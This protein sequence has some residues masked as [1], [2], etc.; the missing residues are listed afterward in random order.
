MKRV[1][2]S[3]ALAG[4]ACGDLGVPG[5]WPLPRSVSFGAQRGQLSPSFVVS[6]IEVGMRPPPSND[7]K[8]DMVTEAVSRYS[9]MCFPVHSL[10]R[11][12][13]TK[14]ALQLEGLTIEVPASARNPLD[15][16]DAAENYTLN[17]ALPKAVLSASSGVGVLRGLETFCQMVQQDSYQG[18]LSVLEAKITDY[19]RFGFRGL[20]VDTSRHFLPLDVLR[21]HVDAMLYNKMNVLHW[22]IVDGNS[23]PYQSKVF[24]KL[25]QTAAYTDREVYT[26]EDIQ[27]FVEFSRL[28]GVRVLPEFDTPGHVF[29]SWGHGYPEVVTKCADGSTGPLRVDLNSTYDFLTKLFSEIG[30]VFPDSYLHLGGDEVDFGCWKSNPDVAAFM[31]AHG[32]D[33]AGLENYYEGRLLDLVGKLGKS[34]VV[35]QEIFNNGVH[36]KPDTVIDVWKGFDQKTLAQ[37]TAQNFTVIVSGGWYLDDGDGACCAFDGWKFYAQD[38]ANFDGGAQAEA[39]GRLLGGKACMWGEHVDATNSISRIW[40][41]AS[42]VGERLW[43]DASAKDVPSATPRLKSF[44]CSLV[45]RGI[46]AEPVDPGFCPNGVPYHYEPPYGHH[47]SPERIIV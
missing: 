29:P 2:L 36:V 39:S 15:L 41:R 3:S 19:P 6:I 47:D 43:S 24:P 26:I 46:S 31:Q 38:P 17:I 33:G 25:S 5:L 18:P 23:F 21:Q 14:S 32:F 30:Q 35:W 7:A 12:L 11:S 27:D 8:K 22:H 42:T 20:L 10:Q 34:Y 9:D 13:G 4:V 45:N 37:A 1:L 40:P 28:R 16:K 44:R